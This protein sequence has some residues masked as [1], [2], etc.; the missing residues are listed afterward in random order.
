MNTYLTNVSNARVLAPIHGREAEITHKR[1]FT[2]DLFSQRFLSI[3]GK[4]KII[5]KSKALPNLPAKP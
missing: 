3:Q 2:D 5:G 4:S 1:A